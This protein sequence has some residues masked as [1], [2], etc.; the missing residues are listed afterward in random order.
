VTEEDQAWGSHLRFAHVGIQ[1][2]L[3]FGLIFYGGLKLD[4][5]LKTTPLWTLVGVFTGFAVA[6]YHLYRE[7]KRFEEAEQSRESSRQDKTGE[8]E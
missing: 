4:K 2:A 8:S 3:V 7:L 6:L 5:H 1:F